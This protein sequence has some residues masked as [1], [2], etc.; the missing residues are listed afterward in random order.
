MEA[1]CQKFHEDSG[2]SP[3]EEKDRPDHEEALKQAQEDVDHIKEHGHTTMTAEQLEQEELQL[4]KSRMMNEPKN[5]ISGN[6]MIVFASV[7]VISATLHR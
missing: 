6:L 7:G 1:R 4:E 3:W 5:G 2:F